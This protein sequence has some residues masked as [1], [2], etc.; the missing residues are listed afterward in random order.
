MSFSKGSKFV[1]KTNAKLFAM[2][3]RKGKEDYAEIVARQHFVK[4]FPDLDIVTIMYAHDSIEQLVA[5]HPNGIMILREFRDTQYEVIPKQFRDFTNPNNQD[6]VYIHLEHSGNNM[7][8][9]DYDGISKYHKKQFSIDY[10]F[11]VVVDGKVVCQNALEVY[12]K[13][14]EGPIDYDDQRL[15]NEYLR[16]VESRTMKE[17]CSIRFI[18]H[19]CTER[20]YD[21]RLRSY[22]TENF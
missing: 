11:I 22:Y 17:R 14:Y 12:G 8:R 9:C 7:L 5:D 13:E 3:T 21:R 10:L 18:S 16:R 6:W 20:E 2:S 4:R 15:I 1:G 19:H